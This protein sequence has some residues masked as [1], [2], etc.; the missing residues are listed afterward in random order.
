M[1]PSITAE[2]AAQAA[3][4]VRTAIVAEFNTARLAEFAASGV[5]AIEWV[6]V[7]DDVTTDICLELDGKQWLMPDEDYEGYIPIDHDVPFPGTVAH[8]NCRSTQVP[9]DDEDGA[10]ADIQTPQSTT[11]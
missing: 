5:T 3:T 2:A 8:F 4:L 6:S 1:K 11:N 7:L 10:L 9:V